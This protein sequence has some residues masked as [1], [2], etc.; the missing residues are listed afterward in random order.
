MEKTEISVC[1]FV[2]DE[3][4]LGVA[5][6][7]ALS[8]RVLCPPPPQS[9]VWV[10]LPAPGCGQ[11]W[12]TKAHGCPVSREPLLSRLCSAPDG[13]AAN[14]Q[15]RGQTKGTL[16]L[17]AGAP[18]WWDA[19]SSP[20]P[21]LLS[22]PLSQAPPSGSCR[23]QKPR[24]RLCGWGPGPQ[25]LD[26]LQRVT[27]SR[28][29]VGTSGPEALPP[30]TVRQ[31]Q[32]WGLNL[33]LWIP[34]TRG[35]R[36]AQPQQGPRGVDALASLGPQPGVPSTGNHSRLRGGPPPPETGPCGAWSPGGWWERGC[37]QPGAHCPPVSVR[38]GT[39]PATRGE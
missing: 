33:V 19:G 21:S 27:G 36:R 8:Q 5:E 34:G 26:P 3:H 30:A 32:S 2:P 14:S 22:F 6:S 12:P 23:H 31:G 20:D 28:G 38:W 18:M 15:P 39:F 35:F 11:R 29:Q 10:G 7:V 1:K 9:P 4:L 37:R 24:L 13:P 25:A 16:L 17:K